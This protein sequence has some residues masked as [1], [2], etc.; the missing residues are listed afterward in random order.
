MHLNHSGGM[1]TRPQGKW[2]SGERQ[3][4]AS[5]KSHAENGEPFFTSLFVSEFPVIG[6]ISAI[7]G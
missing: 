3:S 1:A 6:A 2:Y 4:V 7:C 5:L